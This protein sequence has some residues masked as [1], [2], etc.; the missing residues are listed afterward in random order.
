[1]RLR[2][3]W[4]L[5]EKAYATSGRSLQLIYWM[6]SSK[7]ATVKIGKIGPKISCC[8]TGSHSLTSA[9][10]VGAVDKM[11]IH[12]KTSYY[13]PVQLPHLALRLLFPTSPPT[14]GLTCLLCPVLAHMGKNTSQQA[15][16]TPLAIP[17]PQHQPS[18][19]PM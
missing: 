13:A 6:A 3:T 8:M 17:T 7:P 10:T 9:S 2:H 18:C 19:S 12:I 4:R 11:V 14:A 15:F 5:Q 16:C 1:M